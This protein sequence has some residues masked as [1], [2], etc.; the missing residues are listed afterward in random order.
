[1]ALVLRNT[2]E[3]ARISS[4]KKVGIKQKLRPPTTPSILSLVSRGCQ[5]KYWRHNNS[6]TQEIIACCPAT[7]LGRNVSAHNHTRTME[8]K[9]QSKVSYFPCSP[10]K[11]LNLAN[12]NRIIET[13][14]FFTVS[15]D[16]P[17]ARRAQQ[18]ETFE[19]I[20]PTLCK[21]VN[22]NLWDETRDWLLENMF[23]LRN[24]T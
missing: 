14:R 22:W 9:S 20:R 8:S 6:W 16:P 21:I 15:R 18:N 24:P 10:R 4:Y 7:I 3:M 23:E 11:F 13:K 17:V 1:M 12:M 19:K 5:Q 2:F